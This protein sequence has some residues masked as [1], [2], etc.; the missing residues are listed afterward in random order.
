MELIFG[1]EQIATST[2]M[3]KYPVVGKLVRK[4]IGY[5]NLGNYARAG[6]FKKLVKKLPLDSFSKVLDLGCGYGEYSLMMARALPKAEVTALDIDQKR[7]RSVKEAINYSNLTNISTFRNYLEHLQETDFD[8]IFSVDVFEHIEVEKMPFE[9]SF[10]KLKQGGYLLVKMPNKQQ[11]TLMPETWFEEHQH[12]LENE[13][14]GQ[15][16]NLQDLKNRFKASGFEIVYAS[17]SDG[18]LSRLGWEIAYLGKKG[19]WIF[20]ALSLMLAKLLV[21]ADRLVHSNRWGN[22]IQVIG[23]KP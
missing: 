12:W 2:G 8:F 9:E 6:I 13:H 10:R 16:Y 19:G 21:N 7:I 1:K 17:Y 3:K 15:V 14:V 11:R 5:T 4:T 22:A 23:R 18:W 20:Q